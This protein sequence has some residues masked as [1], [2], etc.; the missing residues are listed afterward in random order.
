[1][2]VNQIDRIDIDQHPQSYKSCAELSGTS[3][4][5]SFEFILNRLEHCKQNHTKCSQQ[6]PTFQPSRLIRCADVSGQ[7]QLVEHGETAPSPSPVQ[8]VALSYC[9]G[10][11]NFFKMTQAN[12]DQ[13]KQGFSCSD[14]PR[15]L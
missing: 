7:L 2:L 15:R 12:I 11:A 3:R 9:W 6:S 4:D 10:S 13:L 1:M 5:D 14:L 8:Y